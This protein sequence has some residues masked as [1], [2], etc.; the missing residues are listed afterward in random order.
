MPTR[1]REAIDRLYRT[2]PRAVALVEGWLLLALIVG[3]SVAIG[4]QSGLSSADVQVAALSAAHQAEQQRLMDINRQ[5][6]LIIQD[7]L[8]QIADTAQGAAETAQVAAEKAATAAS[9]AGAAGSTAN[10]AA[11]TAKKAAKAAGDAARAVD[12][13]VTPAPVTP[14]EAPAWHGGS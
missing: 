2:H 9:R 12:Q 3:G 14:A 11:T 4:R 7:R 5:L 1:I 13:A 8:P 10:T 6:M